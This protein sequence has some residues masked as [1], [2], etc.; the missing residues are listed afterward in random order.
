MRHPNTFAVSS[1]GK[2]DI[3]CVAGGGHG[4]A[5]GKRGGSGMVIVAYPA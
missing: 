1:D 2:C 5:T 3:L 4:L